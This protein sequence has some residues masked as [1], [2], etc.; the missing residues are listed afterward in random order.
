MANF[1]QMWCGQW[2]GWSGLGPVGLGLRLVGLMLD[3]L[4]WCWDKVEL[5]GLVVL[6]SALPVPGRQWRW[7][8]R[9]V[10]SKAVLGKGPWV[11]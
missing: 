5:V 2:P 7:R 1:S 4:E 10:H 11:L 6:V 9:M 8:S 3:C